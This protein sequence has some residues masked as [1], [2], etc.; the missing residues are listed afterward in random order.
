MV[1]FLLKFNEFNQNYTYFLDKNNLKLVFLKYFVSYHTKS[2]QTCIEKAIIHFN[3][4]KN[5][6]NSTVISSITEASNISIYGTRSWLLYRG[7]IETQ[8]AFNWLVVGRPSIGTQ[9][10]VLWCI[11]LELTIFHIIKYMGV[12]FKKELVYQILAAK[13]IQNINKKWFKLF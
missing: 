11:N 7:Y 8:V 3:N 13:S 5:I 4:V 2:I 9:V 10:T 1:L 12:F 6:K